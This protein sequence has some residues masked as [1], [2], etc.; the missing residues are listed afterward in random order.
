MQHIPPAYFLSRS[1]CSISLSFCQKIP[2]STMTCCQLQ[3]CSALG[4]CSFTA[5][6]SVAQDPCYEAFRASLSN[7]TLHAVCDVACSFQPLSS[8]G[9][10]SAFASLPALRTSASGNA[11]IVPGVC[12]NASLWN[13][14][15]SKTSQVC[16]FILCFC[17][18]RW[19]ALLMVCEDLFDCAPPTN[20]ERL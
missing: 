13:T 16:V 19:C 1:H 3:V 15:S 11:S 17:S 9:G 6:C 7:V 12:Y 20:Y 2:T 10:A 8:A 18:C 14:C 4:N 5:A